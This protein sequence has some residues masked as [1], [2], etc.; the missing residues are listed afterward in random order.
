VR[1]RKSSLN[2]ARHTLRQMNTLPLLPS[3][4]F[5]NDTPKEEED[6]N[7]KKAHVYVPL[8]HLDRLCLLCE[9]LS[10]LPQP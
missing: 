6:G 2:P 4:M 7:S 3:H 10:G 9:S 1:E 8:E 5:G